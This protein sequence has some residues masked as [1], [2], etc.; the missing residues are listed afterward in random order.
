MEKGSISLRRRLEPDAVAV[1]GI[2][3]GVDREFS[4][5]GH[6]V[7][8][9]QPEGFHHLAVLQGAESEFSQKTISPR[10]PDDLLD[11][12]RHLFR[13]AA[14][15]RIFANRQIHIEEFL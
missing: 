13:R 11:L 12:S 3:Q 8:D 1:V 7:I 5:F 10:L 14:D 4:E 2:V 6:D 9:E 15:K